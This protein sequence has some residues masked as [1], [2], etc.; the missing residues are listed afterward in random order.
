MTKSRDDLDAWTKKVAEVKEQG[1]LNSEE[2]A[3]LRQQLDTEVGNLQEKISTVVNTVEGFN[4]QLNEQDNLQEVCDLISEDVD[5][6]KSEVA[7]MK[8][9]VSN[10]ER[11]L[12]SVKYEVQGV[13]NKV[14]ASK[15]AISGLQKDVLEV[16]EAV[17][18]LK[19]KP[20]Q[21]ENIDDSEAI[22][23]APA[24]LTAFTGCDT[25][26]TWLEQNLTLNDCD[27]DPGT[28]CCC[29]WAWRMW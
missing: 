11:D 12:S 20:F 24:R 16:K 6:L 13:V 7:K 9:R 10:L 22:C 8:S 5:Y 17:E 3:K 14:D 29:V 28:S 23:T 18:T 27:N 19:T 1:H 15:T 21:V 26:L 4:R 2:I 25:S